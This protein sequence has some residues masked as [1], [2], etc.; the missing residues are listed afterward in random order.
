[1][2]LLIAGDDDLIAATDIA[3]DIDVAQGVKISAAAAVDVRS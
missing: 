2:V 1:M 3:G